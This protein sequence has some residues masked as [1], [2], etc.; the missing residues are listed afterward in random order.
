MSTSSWK[1]FGPIL[2]DKE[3]AHQQ[4][5]QKHHQST[6]ESS[7]NSIRIGWVNWFEKR[8]KQNTI[9][10]Q[11]KQFVEQNQRGNLMGSV[12]QSTRVLDCR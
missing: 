7:T 9:H 2:S 8:R 5:R 1:E 11:E 10:E 3:K 4:Q 12:A 6:Q